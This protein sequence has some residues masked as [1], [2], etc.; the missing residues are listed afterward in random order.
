[1]FFLVK[2]A[3]LRALIEWFGTIFDIGKMTVFTDMQS[4]FG[5]K[6]DSAAL[7]VM[8]IDPYAEDGH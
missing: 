1:M 2:E 6:E 4:L 5:R 7:P 3:A 8:G